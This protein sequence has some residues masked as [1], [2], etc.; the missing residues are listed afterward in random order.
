MTNANLTA[1]VAILFAQLHPALVLMPVP[2]MRRFTLPIQLVLVTN[3][4]S[5]EVS[6]EKMS[7]L[8]SRLIIPPEE[9]ATKIA[10]VTRLLAPLELGEFLQLDHNARF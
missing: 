6:L 8:L 4:A 7:E 2:T 3:R 5:E 1:T 9:A 10:P